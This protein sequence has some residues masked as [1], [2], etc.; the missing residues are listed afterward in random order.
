MSRSRRSGG[1]RNNSSNNNN[2]NNGGGGGGGGGGNSNRGGRGVSE[3]DFWGGA[4]R[5]PAPVTSI[6]S[7]ADPTATVRSLGAPPLPGHETVAE[8]YFAAVY[9]KAAKS[10]AALAAALL[11]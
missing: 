1:N 4:H 5:A 10:A 7:A 11:G 3:R 6:R 9:E 8:H 2:N